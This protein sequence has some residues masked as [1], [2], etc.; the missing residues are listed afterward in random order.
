M[1]AGALGLVETYGLV[2]TAEAADAM[3]K[4][5]PVAIEQYEKIGDGY[6]TTIVRGDV[7]AVQAAAQAGSDAAR[8]CGELVACHVIPHPHP[9]VERI[10]LGTRKAASTAD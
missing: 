2:G 10:F 3:A 7:A 5:A 9:D 6:T 8:R 1:L 4:A